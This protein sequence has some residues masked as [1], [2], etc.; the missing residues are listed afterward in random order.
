MGGGQQRPPAGSFAGSRGPRGIPPQIVKQYDAEL[1]VFNAQQESGVGLL[2]D[3]TLREFQRDY[4]NREMMMGPA[5]L[6]CNYRLCRD[7]FERA[8]LGDTAPRVVSAHGLGAR[9]IAQ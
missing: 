7:F 2:A 5:G 3:E 4:Q 1:A 9:S 8:T 6:P